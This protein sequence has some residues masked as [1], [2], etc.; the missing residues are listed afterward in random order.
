MVSPSS[1]WLNGHFFFSSNMTDSY[2]TALICG[3]SV[4]LCSVLF[5]FDIG[6][7]CV[8]N[9][10]QLV[11]GWWHRKVPSAWSG[12]SSIDPSVRHGLGL[13]GC[14]SRARQPAPATVSANQRRTW[15]LVL[16]AR[17]HVSTRDDCRDLK[18]ENECKA[19]SSNTADS[20]AGLGDS[21][22]FMLD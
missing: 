19:D 12:R 22:T 20:G 1:L 2:L 10:N 6:G 7:M 13:S 14:I 5:Y 11:A 15:T 8:M 21:S 17:A 9:K 3:G 16:L 18:M 4:L